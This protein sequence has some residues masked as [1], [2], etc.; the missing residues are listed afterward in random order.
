[1]TRLSGMNNPDWTSPDYDPWADE[2]DCEYCD[3]WCEC[4]DRP[5]G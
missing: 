1:M 5:P 2:D 4:C 3:E